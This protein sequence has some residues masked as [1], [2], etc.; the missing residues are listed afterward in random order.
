[1][2]KVSRCEHL[3]RFKMDERLFRW[4]GVKVVFIHKVGNHKVESHLGLSSFFLNKE[5]NFEQE[6]KNHEN[7][8]F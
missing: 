2:R 8:G 3:N 7:S 6:A 1:M 4:K 5:G